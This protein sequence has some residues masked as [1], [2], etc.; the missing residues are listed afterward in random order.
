MESRVSAAASDDRSGGDL[1]ALAFGTTVAMWAIGYICRFPGVGAP[2]WLVMALLLGCLVLGGW[3]AGRYAGRG[4]RGGLLV[5]ALVGVLN[6]LVLGSLLAHPD[7]PNR[8]VPSASW[9]V[10]GSLLAAAALGGLGAWL[11][12]PGGRAA[13]SAPLVRHGTATFAVVAATATFLLLVAG[14]IVTGSRAGLAVTDWPNS[15]GYNM[16]LYPLARMTGGIYY[17]HVHRLL[18]SRVGLTTLVLAIHLARVED[19]R[20]LQRLAAAALGLVIVQGLLGG[21]RVT[22][23]FT[24]SHDPEVTRPNLALAVVH[25]VTGQL[26]FA[27]MV[28]IAAFLAPAWREGPPASARPGA[29]LDRRLAAWL[30]GAVGVQLVLGALLRHTDAALH[31]HL[32]VAVVVLGLGVL[33]GS[34]LVLRHGDLPQLRRLGNLLLGGLAGQFLLGFAAL[35]ARN[36]AG[37]GGSPHPADVVVT[38]LHQ[39]VGAL[40][41]AA[42]VLCLLWSRRLLRPATG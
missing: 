36:L 21:L 17:E 34:R 3:T 12:R 14:G 1:L 28:A 38:T 41:L 2:A 6:L 40:I 42:T 19:R 27:T 35:F 20:W 16:F 24:L 39:A 15:Y 11:G 18:G 4:A 25:G 5:G 31:A 9:W 29:R 23:H 26:F 10:P 30:L 7:D 32:T 22:G 37:P 8:L 13:R 33:A